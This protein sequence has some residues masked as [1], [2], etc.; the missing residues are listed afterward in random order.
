MTF[1]EFLMIKLFER[2]YCLFGWRF[3]INPYPPTG[4]TLPR[5]F[6]VDRDYPDGRNDFVLH[7]FTV[8]R[9]PHSAKRKAAWEKSRK[10]AGAS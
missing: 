4:G 3:E 6:W 9:W 8:H 10:D 2:S 1:K 7:W 5:G